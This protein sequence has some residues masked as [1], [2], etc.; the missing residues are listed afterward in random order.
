M[1]LKRRLAYALQVFILLM[2]KLPGQV[3]LS[4]WQSNMRNHIRAHKAFNDMPLWTGAETTDI[5]LPDESSGLT[6][7]LI[8]NGY[9]DRKTWAGATPLY[10][11]EVKATMSD[12]NREFYMSSNQFAR[13]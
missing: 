10:C 3:Y 5:V 2:S 4:D 9:L 12:R 11:I 8:E 1:E 6:S 7:L 13:V